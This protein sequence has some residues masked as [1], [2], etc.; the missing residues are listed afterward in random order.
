MLTVIK[1]AEKE[2]DY[3]DILKNCLDCYTILPDL[4][5]QIIRST[6]SNVL[7]NYKPLI[8]VCYY[9]CALQEF[10]ELKSI[11]RILTKV[12]L[13][14]EINNELHNAIK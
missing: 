9:L 6:G 1:K 5:D 4:I 13:P 11:K 3:I 7:H 10:E 14:E 2:K 8:Y 12:L